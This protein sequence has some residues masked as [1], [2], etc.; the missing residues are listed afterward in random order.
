MEIQ[1]SFL[2][3]FTG[4]P[5]GYSYCLPYGYN[6]AFVDSADYP[7]IY[8]QEE[9]ESELNK[10]RVDYIDKETEKLNKEKEEGEIDDLLYQK[11]IEKV[12]EEAEQ[13]VIRREEDIKKWPFKVIK[14]SE[15]DKP[16]IEVEYK[17]K[18]EK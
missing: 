2:R 12:N 11:A 9:Y 6:A 16:L 7:K 17:G 3:I 14:D 4:K 1:D 13:R 8:T 15:K 18:I 10:I 5:R